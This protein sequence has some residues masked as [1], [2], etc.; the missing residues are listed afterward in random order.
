[1]F[2]SKITKEHFFSIQRTYIE[3]TRDNA[4]PI[5]LQRLMNLDVPGSEVLSIASG[6][7]PYFSHPEL[8]AEMIVSS[9]LT[10]LQALPFSS[11]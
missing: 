5:E 1:M 3:C 11:G 10:K 6:Y 4:I 7:A 2:V 8:L 9:Y